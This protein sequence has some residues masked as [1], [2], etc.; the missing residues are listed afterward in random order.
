MPGVTVTI[1]SP[2]LQGKRTDTTGPQGKYVFKFLPPGKYTITFELQ[3][4]KPLTQTATLELNV[5]VRSDAALEPTATAEITVTAQATTAQKVA[6]NQTTFDT[7]QINALPIVGRT[8]D[9]IAALAPEVTQN[10]PNAGQL[11]I[12]GGFAYD[13]VFLVDG[14]DIDDHYFS[15]PTSS[16]VIEDA[17][18][19]TQ[20]LTSNVSAQYGRFTGG[21]VNAVTKS[22]G[23]QYHGTF[24]VDFSNDSW[25]ANTPFETAN[26]VTQPD[27]LNNLYSA[28]LGG[29][30]VTDKLWF[31]A[32]GRYF[33]NSNQVTLPVTGETFTSTDKEPRIQAKLTGNINE[34]HTLQAAYV[35][36]NEELNRVAFD[37]T[38]DPHAQEFPSFPTSLWI[39]TYQGV[40]TPN[41]FASL[42]FSSK[43][44]EFKGA[45]GTSTNI[46]D[47]P[48][49]QTD[50]VLA[51]YNAPYFD[52]T[53]PE[54][55]NNQQ[56]TGSLNYF[57]TTSK[58]GTHDL[59][60]G[61]E[62][63]TVN[64]VGGNSQSA[65]NYVLYY[66]NYAADPSGQPIYDANGRIQPTFLGLLDGGF[67]LALNWLPLRGA[68]A[69]LHTSSAYFNDAWKITNNLSANLGVRYEAVSGTGPTGASL[70]KSSSWVPRLG[71]G[72][73]IEGNGRY[74]LSGSYAGYAGGANPNN[75]LGPT[76]V[77]NPNLVYYLYGGPPGQGRDFA[78][79]FDLSNYGNFDE[80]GNFL[81]GVPIG[82]SFPAYNVSN[83]PNLKTPVTWEWTVSAGGQV[84]PQV[85]GA[86]T[87]VNRRT[88]NFIDN[89]TT[90]DN[91]YT[92]VVVD[93]VNYGN[94]DNTVY[95]NTND[96]ERKYSA[97]AFQ[98]RYGVV[99]NLGIDLNYTYMIQYQGNYEG[100]G[101]NTPAITPGIGS[102]PEILVPARNN[103]VGNLNGLQ[104]H[105]LR[106]LTTYNLPTKF[107]N[108]GFGLIYGFNSG[109]P[110]SY[111]MTGF[112]I[113]Q[114]QKSRDPGYQTPPTSQV[115]YFGARG[116]QTYPSQSRFDF[117]LN[118]DIPVWKTLAPWLKASVFNVF[119][120]SYRTG[121]D[122][123]V[124]C[125]DGSRPSKGCLNT[126]L[127][128]N[129]LPT[130]FA[131]G[132]S[133]GEARGVS[134]YQLSRQFVLS[135]GIQF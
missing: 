13:N 71:V 30:I 37:F 81:P 24:R 48:I 22:G 117:A 85:Y 129:G 119:N 120:S 96:R 20:V 38:I 90:F 97:I 7:K 44:F 42:Q 65:T 88:T 127:D 107:G 62:L 25:T 99:R 106:V 79:G 128:A 66:A 131:N 102:Y 15:N 101:A 47:S 92:T 68:S 2:S 8:I 21:V 130:T 46:I 16:L 61:G 9:Q 6:V 75:F 51:A 35:Y 83:D 5:S 70:T 78:P 17:V 67:Q 95:Q 56:W 59:K 18:L 93:G 43:K 74:V 122:V 134:D 73:D 58:L 108:F 4:M 45:G 23:N 11:K 39:A 14:A 94:F 126:P 33:S 115:L 110:Y 36:S 72:Y 105:K 1:E 114:I 19:E 41:L 86:V 55:R 27:K 50:P 87:Y 64:E 113:S 112:P 26:D 116:S 84:S 109:T 111:R 28:T 125:A 10:T 121:Y 60:V 135:A 34:S 103:P 77:G 3:G 132:S 57:L 29:K 124:V 80:N 63:F 31:F 32:A 133:F 82:G 49:I 52:A 123:G 118:Y 89:F 53:D 104:R 98:G 69:K 40:L 91:G 12:N 54:Q 76:N 100:E